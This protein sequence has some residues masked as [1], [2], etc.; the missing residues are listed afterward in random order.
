MPVPDFDTLEPVEKTTDAPDF[1]SLQPVTDESSQPASQSLSEWTPTIGDRIKMAASDLSQK[2]PFKT[3]AQIPELVQNEAG[4]LKEFGKALI[5]KNESRPMPPSPLTTNWLTGEKTSL[6]PE[7]VSTGEELTRDLGLPTTIT[8]TASGINKVL[9]GF[10]EFFTSPE[11]VSQLAA[12]E[13][14]GLDI[15]VLSKWTSG[16]VDAGKQQFGQF[17]DAAKRNDTQGMRDSI[18]GLTGTI[19]ALAG[20]GKGVKE[21]AAGYT[22]EGIPEEVS[23]EAPAPLKGLDAILEAATELPFLTG[24]LLQMPK[25]TQPPT[26][27]EKN[28]TIPER[29]TEALPLGETAKDS[30]SMGTRE[31]VSDGQKGVPP[32]EQGSASPQGGENGIPQVIEPVTGQPVPV[33]EGVDPETVAK[34]IRVE[35]NDHPEV[36][37][38]APHLLPE[39]VKDELAIDP[40]A[41]DKDTD[42]NPPKQPD[43]KWQVI[44]Q[45]PQEG[46]PGYVQIDDVSGGQNKWSK[47]PETLAKEGVQ[48]PDF[49]KLPQ[50]KYTF[51]QAQKLLESPQPEVESKN[52]PVV[53]PQEA[54]GV[55]PAA[56]TPPEQSL[57]PAEAAKAKEPAA[58]MKAESDELSALRKKDLSEDGLAKDE[59]QR[60]YELSRKET[61]SKRAAQT[62]KLAAKLKEQ[63]IEIPDSFL[64]PSDGVENHIHSWTYDHRNGMMQIR[65]ERHTDASMSGRLITVKAGDTLTD[66]MDDAKV[67]TT[68]YREANPNAA[69]KPGEKSQTPP[70]ANPGTSKLS[71]A[72]R[73]STP[74]SLGGKDTT[75]QPATQ[76]Q[77]FGKVD[78][79]T[80]GSVSRIRYFD[81]DGNEVGY[82]QLD[83][84]VINYVSVDPKYQRQGYGSEIVKD[85]K[86]RGGKIGVSGTPEGTALMRSKKV[87]ANE[88]EPNKF[89]FE[90]PTPPPSLSPKPAQAQEGV[91]EPWQIKQSDFIDSNINKKD[92]RDK[93][94]VQLVQS[95]TS[96]LRIRHRQE[97]ESALSEGKSVPPEVLADY[98]DLK[99][100]EHP[101]IGELKQIEAMKQKLKAQSMIYQH[102]AKVDYAELLGVPFD[103]IAHIPYE[104]WSALQKD[105]ETFRDEATANFKGDG[106]T[107]NGKIWSDYAAAHPEKIQ[108]IVEKH[109]LQPPSPSVVKPEGKPAVDLEQR[110]LDRAIKNPDAEPS[111]AK[112]E[113]LGAKGG[114]TSD[115]VSAAATAATQ[116]TE[117]WGK[118]VTEVVDP[119]KEKIRKI[120]SEVFEMT[121][122]A[123]RAKPE[124]KGKNKL[125]IK[126]LLAKYGVATKDELNAIYKSKN[127]EW[128]DLEKQL[129]AAESTRKE[130]AAAKDKR[131]QEWSRAVTRFKESQPAPNPPDLSGPG[132]PSV[133]Q[134]PDT[135]PGW[136]EGSGGDVYGIAQRVRE[137]RAKA[138]QVALPENGQGVSAE[139]ATD[140][141]RELKRS[142]ADPEKSMQDFEKTKA[143]SFD[144]IALARAHG[145]DLAQSARQI[146]SKFGTDSTAYRT[147][148]KALDDWDARSKAIQTEWHKQGM[149]Q[150]GQ[151]DLDTGSFTGISRAFKDVTGEDLPKYLEPKARGIAKGVSDADKAVE[152]AK[153]SLQAAIDNLTETGKPRY[154]DTIIKIAEKI[155]SSLDKR[156]DAARA[157]IRARAFTF[158]ANI[159]PTVLL[160]VAEIGASHI[161]HWGLDFA[162][163]SKVMVDEF[164]DK[165]NPHLKTIFDASQKLVDAEGDKHGPNA[166]IVK[167]AVKKTG[168]TKVPTDL[169]EQQKVFQDYQSGK[170]MTPIQVKTLWQRAK[171][172][173]INRGDTNMGDTVHNLADDLGIPAK[174][175]LSGL[176]QTKQVKRIADDVWQKQRQ[177]RLLKQ[178]AK[179]WIENSQQT[180]L[181]KALPATA[182]TMFSM[183][184]GLHGTVALGTHAPLVVATH[185]IVFAENFGKMYKLVASPEYFEMQKSELARRDNYTIAQR[186]GLVN[187]MNK[188]EDFNDPQ[189]A[190]GFPKMAAWFKAQLDKAHLGKMVGMGTRGYSVLKI[191]RQDLFD[192]EWDKLPESMKSDSMA[193]AIADSVN[194]MTG[195]TKAGAG[196]LGKAASYALFAPK[197][198]A[199]RV[200]V[201]VAD[202]LRAANSLIKM[203]DATP[204][205]KWFAKNQFKEKAKVF[206]VASGLLL[207]NQ[208]LNNL[209]GDKKKLNGVPTYLG[210]GG[211]NPMESDFMKFRVAGMNFAWGSPFLT[212][213]RLP[214]RLY[215]I[216]AGNGGKTRFLVYPDESMY[217]TLGS[218]ARTQTSPFLSPII[219]VITKGDYQDRP[220]PQIPGYGPPPPVP[221]RLVKQGVK[222]YTWTEFL[223]DIVLPIPIEQGINDI[224]HSS[225]LSTKPEQDH[226]LTKAFI[227]GL[228]MA[229]TGGRL[230]DDWNNESGV[231]TYYGPP[232]AK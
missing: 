101:I 94:K 24:K 212:M 228:V 62:S 161:A 210:G 46:V 215:Q 120:Q 171:D 145:E 209:F 25:G 99:T 203:G 221:K 33:I 35:A 6:A 214:L 173:Y 217:K 132:I 26:I 224:W 31:I 91:K 230:S 13:V 185:P 12:L 28:A 223:S 208:Q 138:G 19:E 104:K 119:L 229:G 51:E 112:A 202:P 207:A 128:A 162:K 109:D 200:A 157:R 64:H 164:G 160:D 92:L 198:E 114:V 20:M 172:E 232:P 154:S 103:S 227:T 49:S 65:V 148:K 130:L 100:T 23:R 61:Q 96:A 81:K 118:H 3:I 56:A 179:H 5:G 153:V 183:K 50:G 194:H 1:D 69:T 37:A 188:M 58:M 115:T 85:L 124:T 166:E 133:R 60:M 27:G 36:L 29:V 22:K 108:A 181:Q 30:G 66:G 136:V 93:R 106:K 68:R 83:G 71:P 78:V 129:E 34:A 102:D 184:V 137:A 41:Y 57:P 182:K 156:A 168:G 231:S 97:V 218:Y 14:P 175:V 177:A 186:N 116:A 189:L 123:N 196:T 89:N 127:A 67:G 165:I 178:S 219:S 16:L 144:L 226:A 21:K 131:G 195:V 167:K 190:Q 39:I 11:G 75:P 141:G 59:E 47:S 149:A 201:M 88:Y 205:E 54:S 55:A 110:H 79:K 42:P 63:G 70:G 80:S 169:V 90:K 170:P 38:Q 77:R 204:A 199:S 7:N 140:W 146:E 176:S 76:V 125:T 72:V 111:P 9:S 82:G 192:H 135:G 193:K 52:A 18:L 17:L 15:A 211:W 73:Q 105:V 43:P 143:T 8:E 44:V 32:A 134:D 122:D 150:Q 113:T 139:A 220:L 197:L 163:W 151:T 98:P 174:D 74:Q 158:G 213:A 206:A 95:Q 159:D 121:M 126:A 117:A 180:W 191:L 10:G 216:G 142:G 225:E 53:A 87:G 155:V 86:Q 152:P 222:P 107:L 40:K 187:D 4:E 48:V 84:D 45:E 2:Q 147:A